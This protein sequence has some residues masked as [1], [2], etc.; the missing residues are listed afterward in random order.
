MQ[1]FSLVPCCH[2]EIQS[3]VLADTISGVTGGHRG[4]GLPGQVSGMQTQLPG[5]ANSA[6]MILMFRLPGCSHWAWAVSMMAGCSSDR[7]REIW[8][9]LKSVITC[10]PWDDGF[11]E[12]T[13]WHDSWF[14]FLNYIYFILYSFI[15]W[16]CLCFICP[17]IHYTKSYKCAERN[18]ER[19]NWMCRVSMFMVSLPFYPAPQ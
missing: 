7:H 10:L 18:R 11:E 2:A 14:F 17:N 4:L 8:T 13:L 9:L 1:C 19:V 6:E 3:H 16:F 5:L 12:K 15:I